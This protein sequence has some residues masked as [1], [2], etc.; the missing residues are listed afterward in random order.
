[1]AQSP[2]CCSNAAFKLMS[3]QLPKISSPEALLNGAIAVSMHQLDD[4]D[5]KGIDRQIKC[6]ADRV[7]GRVHGSQPQALLAH[8]HDVLFDDEG[9]TGSKDDY[10]NPLNSYLPSVLET[11]KGLPITLCLI[12]KL[13]A[14]RLGLRSW[15]V[16]LPGHFLAGVECG[17]DSLLVDCFDHGRILTVE[18]AQEQM[19]LH[20]G[21]EVEWSAE[22]LEPVSN[23]RF[24]TR[25]LQNLLNL[26]SAEDHYP[27]VA[28]MLELE[29]LLWPDQRHLQRDLALV[30]ARCGLSQPAAIW[31]DRYLESN[32]DDP[33]MPEL[34]QLREV[35]K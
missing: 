22:M 30:L 21:P 2:L 25:M 31:L 13:V 12:Y 20:L 3:R 19:V 14:E 6:L 35:L 9:F 15:G 23:R 29:M 11:R 16:G 28:A 7:K 8:L 33:Q 24:L 34:R 1:M 17:D 4:V 26:F 27:D 18:E 32:P 10:Y 5:V